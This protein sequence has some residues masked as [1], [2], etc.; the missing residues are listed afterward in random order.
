M[1]LPWGWGGGTRYLYTGG[2]GGAQGCQLQEILPES[3]AR[4]LRE[5]PSFRAQEISRH[6]FL[7]LPSC[8]RLSLCYLPSSFFPRTLQFSFL[9]SWGYLIISQV[10]TT[11]PVMGPPAP[12]CFSHLGSP[13]AHLSSLDPILWALRKARSAHS[14]ASKDPSILSLF[15]DFSYLLSEPGEHVHPLLCPLLECSQGLRGLRTLVLP[16]G[17]I[18][19]LSLAIFKLSF[20]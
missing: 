20:L 11:P 18:A 14:I 19:C 16:P 2:R 4:I 13:L 6:L 7:L 10:F 5:E 12:S 17:L 15:F 9:T 1:P 3:S 8:P